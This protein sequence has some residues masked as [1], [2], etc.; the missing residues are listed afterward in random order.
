MLA[1]ESTPC[2]GAVVDSGCRPV[3]QSRRQLCIRVQSKAQLLLPGRKAGSG[4]SVD[5]HMSSGKPAAPPSCLSQPW[6]VFTDLLGSQASLA[7]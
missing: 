5:E 4:S 2:R 3:E 7:L 6:A 1:S